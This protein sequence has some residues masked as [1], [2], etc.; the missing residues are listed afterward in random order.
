MNWEALSE[1][2]G[3][4][5]TS[6]ASEL[7]DLQLGKIVTKGPLLEAFLRKE[8]RFGPLLASY[9]LYLVKDTGLGI[10]GCIAYASQLSSPQE[11][12]V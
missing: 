5:H 12:Q 4:E 2:R 1:R 9:P 3:C 6:L 8:S 7:V 11:S 10:R